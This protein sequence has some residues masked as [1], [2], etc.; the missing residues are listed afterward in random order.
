MR[1]QHATYASHDPGCSLLHAH[2]LMSETHKRNESHCC[3]LV[4][5]PPPPSNHL[6]V[7]HVDFANFNAICSIVQSVVFNLPS[8]SQ[9]KHK[10]EQGE[11]VVAAAVVRSIDGS[12]EHVC[13]AY[14]CLFSELTRRRHQMA[15]VKTMRKA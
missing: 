4:A 13:V 9:R 11:T 10:I 2:V 15:V 14:C 12:I 3:W 8:T 6:S 5:T 1:T 7:S